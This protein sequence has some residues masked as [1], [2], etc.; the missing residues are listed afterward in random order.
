MPIFLITDVSAKD[1]ASFPFQGVLGLSPNVNGD[2][3]STLGV[4]LPIYMRQQGAIG[5]AL[6]GIDMRKG[7]SSTMT[8][9]RFDQ[10]K[11]RN[12]TETLD[13][14]PWF[15]VNLNSR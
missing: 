8:L 7:G 9:G 10:T 13:T 1:D 3:Y 2:T 5:N 15:G 12:T 4:A 11:F 14:I 6:V